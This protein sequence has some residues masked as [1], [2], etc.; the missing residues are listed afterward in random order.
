VKAAGG[1][2]NGIP[3]KGSLLRVT[4]SHKQENQNGS[5][6]KILIVDYVRPQDG[7]AAPVQQ[8]VPAAQPQ[9]PVQQYAPQPV[10]QQP[11]APQQFQQPTP[12]Q[13][14][15]AAPQGMPVPQAVPLDAQA[16]AQFNQLLGGAAPQ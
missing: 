9:Q 16:Q 2:A 11:V 1:P 13:Q 15:M 8:P 7:G 4:F 3:E 10:A 12:A 5:A 14:P 6:S